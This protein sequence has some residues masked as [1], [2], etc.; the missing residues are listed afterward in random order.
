MHLVRQLFIYPIKSMKGIALHSA[1][2]L[3]EG[4]EHDRRWMLIDQT[5]R[6]VSQRE[7]H[8]LA[9]FETQIQAEGVLV[10]YQEDSILVPF[11]AHL[12]AIIEVSV[13]DSTFNAQ[14][15]STD[16]STWFSDRLNMSVRMVAMTD[17]SDRHKAIIKP[18]F[19]TTVSFADGYP[20]LV[21]GEKSM[22]TLNE[23]LDTPLGLDRF[24]GNII[25]SSKIAHEEDGWDAFNIGTAH[26]KVIKPCARC[27][28]TTV[29]QSTGKVGKE[30]LKT[31]S[32][33]RKKD[34]NIYFGAN[35]II[36]K[37]GEIT[38]GDQLL[39]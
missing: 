6:F 16:I 25:V 27:V 5:G 39:F 14:E 11:S 17:I 21:I 38:V 32:T 23:K 33:Y 35:V 7:H 30:P 37:E 31:L 3:K 34:N 22:K 13:W 18:P 2:A 26:L 15:V 29:D 24:R 9:L 8:Q 28:M 36:E 19:D 4:F 12:D 1:K 20:Y 10:S